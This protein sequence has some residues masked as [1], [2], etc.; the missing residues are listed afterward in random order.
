[1]F[2][3]IVTLCL[4][5]GTPCRDQLLPGYEAATEAA[6][7]ERLAARPPDRE[8]EPRC[9]AAGPPLDFE[10]VAPGVHVHRGA[11]EEPDAVNGGDVSNLGFVVGDRAVAVVDTGGAR[12]IGEGTW[13]AIRARTDLPVTHVILTHMHPDHVLGA[14]V[15]EAAGAELVGHAALERALADRAGNYLESF[16]ALIGP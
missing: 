15:F 12:W 10:E 9:A 1:M 11:I 2:E 14:G 8:G 6:C 13:R 4:A 7:Q 16:G 5:G 3:A